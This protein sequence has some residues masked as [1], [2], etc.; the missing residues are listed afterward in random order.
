MPPPPSRPHKKPFR[1]S[2]FSTCNSPDLDGFELTERLI[3]LDP[4]LKIVLISSRDV[5]D[6]GDYVEASAAR[7]FVPKAELS[8]A[9][10]AALLSE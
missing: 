2:C 1:R 5:E 10:L 6:F 8:G 4:A 3:V 7:G 9:T